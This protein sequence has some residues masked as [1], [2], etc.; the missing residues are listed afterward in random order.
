MIHD[1]TK[2]IKTQNELRL[3][4]AAVESVNVGVVIDD[5]TQEDSVVVYA[6]EAFSRITGYERDEIINKNCRVLQNNDKDQP[7]IAIL[8]ES[9]AKKQT[10]DVTL[11]NYK[12]SGEMF[13]NNL[14]LSPVFLED[15]KLNHYIGI[16][17]DVTQSIELRKELESA[18]NAKSEF[19]ANMSHEIRTPLNGIM[20]LTELT[21]ETQLSDLQLDYL[22]KV[23]NASKSLLGIINDILDYSKIEANKIKIIQ[24]K[25]SLTELVQNVNN[26]FGY[27]IEKKGLMYKVEMDETIDTLVIGDKLRISQVLNN[28]MS[29]A[30][31]FTH[32]GYIKFGIEVLER[33]SD[34]YLLRFC[35][36]DSGIGIAQENQDKLFGIFVQEDSTTTKKYGGSGLG[37][38]ISKQLIE[39]MGGKVLFESEKNKGSRFGFELELG[40]SHQSSQLLVS[41]NEEI[42]SMELLQKHNALLVEDNEVNQLIAQRTLQTIGFEVDVASNGEVAVEKAKQKDYDIIFMDLQMP[43]M[44]GY[45][46]T[47][48]IKEFNQKT[49]IIA[50]SAAVMESERVKALQYGMVDH[51]SKPVDKGELL[52]AISKHFQLKMGT[53]TS[54]SKF[55]NGEQVKLSIYEVDYE[56]LVSMLMS[57]ALAEKTLEVFYDSFK[58]LPENLLSLQLQDSEKF[59]HSVHKL[60]GASGNIQ[61]QKISALCKQIEEDEQNVLLVKNLA[62]ELQSLLLSIKTSIVDS[63]ANRMK[64]PF[65][66]SKL[67]DKMDA[68]LQ[69]LE[70]GNFI[71]SELVDEFILLLEASNI[72]S[73]KLE[74]IK[75]YFQSYDYEEVHK[76]LLQMR[77]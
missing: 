63:K 36:E 16:L 74:L 23:K 24:E 55:A 45:E 67:S 32:E 8:K 37:L 48:N 28:F 22:T 14:V 38:A 19:M 7:E 30:L 61:S 26:L 51:I 10:C 75:T 65:D 72:E 40:D 42:V 35:I 25:F 57:N 58:D 6:N 66:E 68:M 56:K 15:N 76:L 13:Y 77:G 11:R 52:S 33:S 62:N 41:N 21:L 59:R 53:A 20:G 50:L 34:G 4:K 29:N 64:Q 2:M 70:D 27:N 44:D 31:K 12:K 71:N 47:K 17:R 54:E 46:A 5:V 60:K 18:N 73:E 1:V 49:P 69:L 39:L 9:I 3:F 43:V